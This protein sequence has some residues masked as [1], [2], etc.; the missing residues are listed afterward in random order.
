MIGKIIVQKEDN[1]KE[2]LVLGVDDLLDDNTLERLLDPYQYN[3]SDIVSVE[4][5]QSSDTLDLSTVSTIA[6]QE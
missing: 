6:T 1:R 5:Q 4:Q 2:I 3:V